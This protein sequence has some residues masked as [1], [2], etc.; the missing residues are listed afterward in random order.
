MNEWMNE[1]RPAP[2][3]MG[4]HAWADIPRQKQTTQ[5]RTTA[6]TNQRQ[7]HL[8]LRPI[9]AKYSSCSN[10]SRKLQY[11]R[12]R[13]CCWFIFIVG[14]ITNSIAFCR[15]RVYQMQPRTSIR[16]SLRTNGNRNRNLCLSTIRIYFNA[17][18]NE[19]EL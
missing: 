19:F 11:R 14:N 10:S 4:R 7:F 13:F 2:Y 17:T 5:W 1:W 3:W 16:N 6:S 8:H 18:A 9:T 12:H 15:T